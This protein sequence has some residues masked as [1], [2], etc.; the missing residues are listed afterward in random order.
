MP[1]KAGLGLKLDFQTKRRSKPIAG[2]FYGDR[3]RRV[4]PDAPVA[5]LPSTLIEISCLSA[6]HKLAEEG[7]DLPNSRGETRF[8]DALWRGRMLVL[9]RPFLEDANDEAR[10]S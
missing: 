5:A 8:G 1:S 6:S 9:T 3:F 4:L 2:H 10:R 7:A